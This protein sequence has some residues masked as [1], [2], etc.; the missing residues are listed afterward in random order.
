LP[1]W[2]ISLLTIGG[3]GLAGYFALRAYQKFSPTSYALHH[4][5]GAHDPETSPDYGTPRY[6]HIRVEGL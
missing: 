3:I 5:A 4:L 1:W 2:G 6:P